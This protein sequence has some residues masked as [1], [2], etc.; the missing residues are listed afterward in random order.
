M[1][2]L[3]HVA[4][5]ALDFSLG[6]PLANSGPVEYPD[7]P[8]HVRL[9]IIAPDLFGLFPLLPLLTLYQNYHSKFLS[10]PRKYHAFVSLFAFVNATF[11][12]IPL[13]IL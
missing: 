13:P 12:R 10:I 4:G 6:P 7:R 2:F 11:P 9:S 5:V 8:W 1:V 3:L